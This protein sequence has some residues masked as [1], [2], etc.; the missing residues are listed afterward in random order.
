MPTSHLLK[1]SLLWSLLISGAVAAPTFAFDP[2]PEAARPAAVHSAQAS[3]F[4]LIGTIT[5][6]AGQPLAGATV[7]SLADRNVSASTNS[8][9]QYL[10][11]SAVPTPQVKVSFAGYFDTTFVATNEGPPVT[12]QLRAVDKYKR[13]KRQ[14]NKQSKAA[15]KAWRKP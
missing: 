4:Q 11:V 15:D 2:D 10:L 14:L 5:N 3:S 6:T 7:A 8:E 13:Y 1:S 12:V 9:G